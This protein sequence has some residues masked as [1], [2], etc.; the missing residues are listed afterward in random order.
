MTR[1]MRVLVES[2]THGYDMGVPFVNHLGRPSEMRRPGEPCA[3]TRDSLLPLAKTSRRTVDPQNVGKHHLASMVRT[4]WAS[5]AMYVDAM[6]HGDSLNSAHG[7]RPNVLMV[8]DSLVFMPS[9]FSFIDNVNV[10][11]EVTI[12]VH[13]LE[14][15]VDIPKSEEKPSCG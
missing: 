7:G 2:E 15:S 13:L 5:D 8:A 3:S 9:Q 14:T 11:D 12:T 1:A 6:L 10:G 4:Q